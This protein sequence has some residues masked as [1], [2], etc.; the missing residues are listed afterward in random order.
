ML[1][2]IISCLKDGSVTFDEFLMLVFTFLSYAMVILLALPVHEL[3]HGLM[4][5][6]LGDNTARWNGR[7]TLNPFAHLDLIG[8]LMIFFL[9]FGY[10]KPV[11]VNPRNFRNY[12]QGMLLTALA[13][14]LSNFLMAVV[15]MGILR[16]LVVMIPYGL[17]LEIC[18]IFL[19]TFT[20]IN[21][22]LAVF[23]LLPIPPLDGFRIVANV[24]PP[25][26]SY[27]VDRYQLYITF[28]VMMLIFSNILS[29]PI[30]F[31][32]TKL[33]DFLLMIYQF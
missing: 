13:G 26:W 7:L 12:K 33:Y 1:N 15:S 14:P 5:D 25:K 29:G 4:A 19:I 18:K 3:A 11:P 22:G 32:V 31:L 2:T 9:G 10:A 30:E 16:I 8:T 24:L 28:V 20:E 6:K 23:N 17:T 21:L 27:F